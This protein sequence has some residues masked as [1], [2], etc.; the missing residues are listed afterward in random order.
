[1]KKQILKLFL[2]L[3]LLVMPLTLA[4]ASNVQTDSSIYV[5]KEEIVG[6]NF[7][8]AGNTITIDGTVSGDLIAAAQ[9]ITVNGRVEGDIIAVAQEIIINGEV[10]GNVRVVGASAVLNGPVARNV[11]FFG[12]KALINDKAH[13]G[14]DVYVADNVTEIRGVIDGNLNGYT[15]QAVIAGKIGKSLDLTFNDQTI[16]GQSLVVSPGAVVNGDLTYTAKNTASISSQA[17]ISG[18]IQQRPVAAK[19]NSGWFVAWLWSRLF[20]IFAALVVGLVL[21][22][23]GKNLTN[24]V[25]V[26]IQDTPAK[27]FWPGLLMLVAVPPISL[28]LIFTIIGLPLALIITTTWLILIY[29]AKVTSALL[30]GQLILKKLSSATEW[31]P[32]WPLILGVLISWLLFS[33]PLLGWL[34][35]LIAICFGL[36][37]LWAV[38]RPAL[39]TTTKL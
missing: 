27:V 15:S 22:F 34:L 29:L 38:S 6:G 14:W 12:T 30:L 9:T 8:A 33:I 25:L 4:H 39:E 2:V 16:S 26:K 18:K 20:E 23:P 35:G 32:I 36:G 5:G 10:G 1:M 11:N 19:V 24:Q 31:K 13:I 17:N 7:Y 28:I 3:T 21:I 37:G